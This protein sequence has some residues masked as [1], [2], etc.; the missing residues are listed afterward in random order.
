[1]EIARTFFMTIKIE[2]EKIRNTSNEHN[3]IEQ[4]NDIYNMELLID[5]YVE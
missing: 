1:M 4:E 5:W 3:E 2:R